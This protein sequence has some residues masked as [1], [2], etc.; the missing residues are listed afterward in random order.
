MDAQHI[1]EFQ[2]VLRKVHFQ[3]ALQDLL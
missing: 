3:T 2:N 1:I